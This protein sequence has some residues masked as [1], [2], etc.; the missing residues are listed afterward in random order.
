MD[1]NEQQRKSSQGLSVPCASELFGDQAA[2]SPGQTCTV[3]GKSNAVPNGSG[4]LLNTTQSTDAE[5]EVKPVT[6]DYNKENIHHSQSSSSSVDRI[7]DRTSEGS[8]KVEMTDE[9]NSQ[10]LAGR[11]SLPNGLPFSPDTTK[12]M[13]MGTSVDTITSHIPM[14]SSSLKK[15]EQVLFNPKLPSVDSLKKPEFPLFPMSRGFCLTLQK[16]LVLYERA[17]Q[18]MHDP[19]TVNS[20]DASK[21]AQ[22]IETKVSD[23]TITKKDSEAF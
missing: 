7:F 6:H 5:Q 21:P 23:L 16:Y 19:A 15:E 8:G 10:K 13:E 11:S 2:N 1:L 12:D 4:H 3:G 9:T 17:L 18:A 14:F 22:E 20:Q